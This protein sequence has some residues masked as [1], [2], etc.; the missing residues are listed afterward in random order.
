MRPRYQDEREIIDDLE[1][2]GD[3]EI[4]FY[5]VESELCHRVLAALRGGTLLQRER[6]DFEDHDHE[7]LL[8][9]MTIDDHVGVGKQDATRARESQVLRELRRSGWDELFPNAV[10]VTNANSGLA[11]D[12]D[13]NFRAYFEHFAAV[14]RKHSQKSVAYRA[15]QPAY[16]LG[17]L[18]FDESTAYLEDHGTGRTNP[19]GR[20][21]M[22]FAD[23]RFVNVLRQS[24]IDY[25]VWFTPYKVIRLTPSSKYELPSL[26]IIDL[27]QINSQ[28]HLDY[29]AERM[30]SSE[31]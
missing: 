21:H 18:L 20:P 30:V 2:L 13:H 3:S 12:E 8:E 27:A 22:W 24:G 7:L 4:C 9:S 1:R 10:L 11:T 15:E 17:F 28:S 29:D 23:E 6:P 26:T 5:P 25:A 31:H 19:T 16:A 14:V